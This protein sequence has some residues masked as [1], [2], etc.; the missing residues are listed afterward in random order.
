MKVFDD[1]WSVGKHG[2]ICEGR[3][4]YLQQVPVSWTIIKEIYAMAVKH[5]SA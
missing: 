4:H 1:V 3:G 5:F 2:Y